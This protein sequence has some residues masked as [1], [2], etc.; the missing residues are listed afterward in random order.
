MAIKTKRIQSPK[1]AIT[2]IVFQNNLRTKM[3]KISHIKIK[4]K[5]IKRTFSQFGRI[6]AEIIS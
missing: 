4:V 1:V 3:G 2:T 6:Y 5:I